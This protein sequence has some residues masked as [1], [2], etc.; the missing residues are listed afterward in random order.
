[1][2]L[3]KISYPA[4]C[5]AGDVIAALAQGI[6]IPF[7]SLW[8]GGAR[9][10]RVSGTRFVKDQVGFFSLVYSMSLPILASST[11]TASWIPRHESEFAKVHGLFIV[12]PVALTEIP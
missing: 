6:G 3:E 8:A 11:R 12:D 5:H 7:V 1:M 9:L 10:R 4:T 2:I